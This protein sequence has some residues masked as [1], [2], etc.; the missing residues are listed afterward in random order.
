MDEKNGTCTVKKVEVAFLAAANMLFGSAIAAQPGDVFTPY[1]Q[2]VRTDDD[3]LL[4]LQNEADALSRFGNGRLSDVV[5][6]MLAGMRFEKTVG[7]Q[8][9]T[10]DIS[11][12]RSQFDHFGQFDYV[13][14]NGQVNWNWMLGNHLQG[15]V[16]AAY[17]QS[18]TP[19]QDYIVLTRNIRTLRTHGGDLAWMLHPDW[20]L[21]T[22]FTR[23]ALAYSAPAL[24]ASNQRADSAE[25]GISYLARSGSSIGL[26]FQTIRGSYATIE[27][28]G[29]TAFN[30]DYVQ[31]EIKV[32]VDW[33]VTG[34][35][36][37]QFLAGPVE[38]KR[39]YFTSRNYT[40]FNARLTG[41]TNPT[42]KLSLGAS[43]WREL[44]AVDD[45][46]ADFALT[47]G[48]SFTPALAISSRLKLEGTATRQRLDYSGAQVIEGLT[49]SNR[50]DKY[51]RT[52]L[53]L[54]YKAGPALSVSAA[55][56]REVRDS[57]LAPFN[58][59][60]NG[61]SLQLRYEY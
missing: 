27:T 4:R 16:A 25:L 38:R 36:R 52:S 9:V 28:I 8:H 41:T 33:L 44:G 7:R 29:D 61:M 11:A 6:T 49:P 48:V 32:S 34:K 23:V 51:Q 3:N 30:N 45:L 21:R 20:R 1:I 54:A 59:R 60:S 15:S 19:F 31:K 57:N 35:S 46:T 13:G 17:D 12:N 10:A 5:T 58:Y 56:N 55:L 22:A 47:D 14:K 39:A 24:A 42:G 2:Y 18:L 43:V 50:R 26:V 40:G 53:S 37:L